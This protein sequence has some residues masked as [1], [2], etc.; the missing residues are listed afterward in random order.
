MAYF[1]EQVTPVVRD[2]IFSRYDMFR[3][4][5]LTFRDLKQHVAG[6]LQMTYEELKLDDF[7]T[8]SGTVSE[9]ATEPALCMQ[10]NGDFGMQKTELLETTRELE[11]ATAAI[12]QSL[13][14]VQIRGGKVC[15]SER[16]ALNALVAGLGQLV[17]ASFVE[18]EQRRRI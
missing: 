14:L 5:E 3:E 6:E 10:E 11:G 15:Q 7:S 16:E 17:E 18:A 12:K 13:S 4:S 9:L 2:F 1:R 8:N